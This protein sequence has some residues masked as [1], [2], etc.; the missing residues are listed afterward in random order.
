MQERVCRVEINED[1]LISNLI[2]TASSNTCDNDVLSNTFEETQTLA[3]CAFIN[4]R[5]EAND[6]DPAKTVS[7]VSQ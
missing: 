7:E 1:P 4:R 6:D 3:T 2:C 5:L